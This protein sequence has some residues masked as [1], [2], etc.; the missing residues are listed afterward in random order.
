MESVVFLM[1]SS[2]IISML[3][4][5]NQEPWIQKVYLGVLLTDPTKK[6]PTLALVC[7][8][9]SWFEPPSIEIIDDE[10]LDKLQIP[11]KPNFWYG[12]LTNWKCLEI[13]FLPYILK[14]VMLNIIDA[15]NLVFC[16]I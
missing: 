2:S 7:I 9:G 16:S 4:G 10:T 13:I 1:F 3:G 15:S 5:S 8:H 12:I 11:W 14:W 6:T